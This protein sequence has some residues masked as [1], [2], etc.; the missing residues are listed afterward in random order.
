MSIPTHVLQIALAEAQAKRPPPGNLAVPILRCADLEVELYAPA[1]TDPQRPHTR[2]ELYVIASGTGWFH[3]GEQRQEFH[4]GTLL[5]VPAGLAHHFADFS[6]DFSAWVM[7]FG[8]EGGTAT[9][10]VE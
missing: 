10:T 8:P 9:I 7:F 4:P 6:A 5:F 2:D 3:A 1:G